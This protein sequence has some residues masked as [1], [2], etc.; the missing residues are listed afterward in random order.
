MS[1]FTQTVQQP[2]SAGNGW[3]KP[4]SSLALVLLVVW[5]VAAVGVHRLRHV[6]RRSKRRRREQALR[7]LR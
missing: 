7:H 1:L 6:A 3:A 2:A 5:I 4:L